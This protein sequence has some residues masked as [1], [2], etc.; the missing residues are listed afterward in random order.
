MR[1]IPSVYFMK[2]PTPRVVY[3]GVALSCMSRSVNAVSSGLRTKPINVQAAVCIPSVLEKISIVSPVRKAI[4]STCTRERLRGIFRLYQHAGACGRP[5]FC[6]LY[7]L[8]A[9][10]Q[11]GHCRD[12]GAAVLHR[13]LRQAGAILLSRPIEP[14][15][16]FPITVFCAAGAARNLAWHL[17][18][19]AYF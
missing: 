18:A 19:Q 6:R 10:G 2:A 13:Q 1:V 15:Q 11:I 8:A 14:E 9:S 7:L 16:S 4:Q 3:D 17:A 12:L 5:A